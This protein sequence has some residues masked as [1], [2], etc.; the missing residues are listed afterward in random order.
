MNRFVYA[1]CMA[2]AVHAHEIQEDMGVIMDDGV[3]QLLSGQHYKKFQEMIYSELTDEFGLNVFD[4]RVLL[5]FDTHGNCNTAK[6]LVKIHHFTKSNVSKSIDV[7]LEKGY[8]T[9]EYD[10]QDRRYIHLIVQ[11]EAAPVL[12]KA[13]Q[14]QEQML[15]MIFQ[16]VSQEERRMMKEVAHKIHENISNA[17][18]II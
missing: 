17:L 16:G 9:K 1:D 8:L 18:T 11:P 12:A 14:C 13:K 10:S 5:F 6:D 7:L 3:E 15:Q 2:T 4:V